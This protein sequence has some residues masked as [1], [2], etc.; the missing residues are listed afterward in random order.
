MRVLVL[1][2]WFP[3]AE[4]PV[5]APFN[6]KHVEAIAHH[7][8]VSIIHVRLGSVLPRQ[9]TVYGG[10]SVV[11]L[12]FTPRR[13]WGLVGIIREVRHAL[14]AAELLHT[15]AFSSAVFARLSIIGTNKPWVHTEHWTGVLDP[16]SVS[17][18]WALLAGTRRVLRRAD[19]L[20]GVTTQLAD[21]LAG[22]GRKASTSVVACV[23]ENPLPLTTR[24]GGTEL[25][26]VAVGTLTDNKRPVM[27]VHTVKWL[28][29]A[30]HQVSMVWVGD[31]PLRESVLSECARL[32]V[33][34][35]FTLAG[36][37]T[38]DAV[39]D[40][41]PEADLFFLPTR[42]ENFFTAA[43]EA[44][45]AGRVVVAGRVGG[46]SDYAD[47]SN[48]VLVDDATPE[49]FGRAI[50]QAQ[51]LS[52]GVTAQELALPIRERFSLPAIGA[53]FTEVYCAAQARRR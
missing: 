24:P 6:L 48:S 41:L 35:R 8:E 4:A 22:F 30:G 13:P 3:S 36:S 10:H 16:A 31:G 14:S 50:L 2:T 32:G 43:A 11:R 40:Y 52:A 5:Q 20:T 33:A 21:V 49:H 28:V 27:A 44:L 38:P 26:L 7:H 29:D 19:W 39:F 53:Q 47:E 37:V 25:R 18:A 17:R 42:R 1:T 46:F 51:Q 9:H 12:S 15:M 34:D 23:V 45:S